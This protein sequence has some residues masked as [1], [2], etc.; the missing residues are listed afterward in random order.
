MIDAGRRP[1]TPCADAIMARQGAAIGDIFA[2]TA[3]VNH[4]RR[5]PIPVLQQYGL[6]YFECVPTP[7][8]Q[9]ALGLKSGVVS[10]GN[11]LDYTD[12]CMEIMQEQKVRGLPAPITTSPCSQNVSM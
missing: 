9:Q 7:S 5:I 4:D 10:S 1:Q 6:G 12:K 8:L 2:T 11:S 3:A